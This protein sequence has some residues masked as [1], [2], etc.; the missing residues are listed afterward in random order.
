MVEG[1][2]AKSDH[3][4]DCWVKNFFLECA[5]C[6]D[7]VD[8]IHGRD[9][10]GEAGCTAREK[11]CCVLEDLQRHMVTLISNVTSEALTDTP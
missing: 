9:D 11:Q 6:E 8:V 10:H 1:S 4:T 3:C 7:L 2:L 5:V